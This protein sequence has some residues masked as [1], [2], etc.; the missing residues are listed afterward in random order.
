[1]YGVEKHLIGLLQ[2]Y[3]VKQI[4]DE[5]DMIESVDSVHLAKEISKIS[6]KKENTTNI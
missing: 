5:V 4:V 1:M 2:S 6:S 3:K